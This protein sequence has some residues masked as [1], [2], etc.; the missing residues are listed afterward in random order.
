MEKPT[1][2]VNAKVVTVDKKFSI[3]EAFA[4]QDGR[5]VKVGTNRRLREYARRTGATV[6]DL[7]GRMV[8]PGFVDGHPHTILRGL[9]NTIEPSLVG[10]RS[11]AEIAATI[12]KEAAK[13]P[14]GQWI[15]TTPIGE[16][17]DYFGL[18]EALTE[19]RW[20]T[21][22]D[23]DA[24]APEHPVYICTSAFWPHPAIFNSVALR[25]LGVDR[26]TP[27][28]GMM[29]IA[30]DDD[31]EAT[32]LIYGLTIF[33]SSALNTRL[34]SLLPQMSPH[35]RRDAIE[36][37]VRENLT[38]GVT[39]IYEAHSNFFIPELRQ[40]HAEARLANRVVSAYEFPNTRSID[41]LDAWMA[42]RTDALGAG[43]GDDHFKV[44]GATLSVDSGGPAFGGLVMFEPY[45]DMYD[46]PC[47]GEPTVSTDQLVE[48]GH[49]AHKHH[50][51]LNILAGGDRAC[52]MATEALA[53]INASTPIAGRGWIL[54][55]ALYPTREQLG[56][57]KD[58]GILAQTCSST[59]FTKGVRLYVNRLTGDRWQNVV[60]LRWWI[61]AGVPIAQAATVPTRSRCSRSGPHFAEWTAR[62]AA[63]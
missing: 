5:F 15:A 36:V 29:H 32:G 17:P 6:V 20:P 44:V 48:I 28:E 53:I 30:R 31:G 21:R 62:L 57:L 14:P 19:H 61:D 37:A 4:V 46:Q 43:T 23:L 35:T 63:T 22:E 13:V 42:S 12:A 59:D 18:P 50:L 54:Q 51:R 38:F 56:Q 60:P 16:P 45:L 27:D 10:L 1:V 34:Q 41:E 40:L 25:L 7:E 3:A 47:N 52:A 55:H 58:M 2:Y 24:A 8:L 33:T 26:N 49:L 9:W 11:V 39:T